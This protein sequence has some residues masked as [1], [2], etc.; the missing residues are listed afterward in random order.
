MKVILAIADTFRR[1]HLS[2]YGDAPWGKIHTPNLTRFASRAAVFDNAFIGSFPTG[3]N[4]RDTI[5]GYC[6]AGQPFNLWTD[7]TRDEATFV[8][9][10]SAKK[11]PSMLI[12]DVQNTVSKAPGLHRDFS[13]WTLVR[14]QEGD[15]MWLDENVPYETPC[16]QELMRYSPEHW[17]R[18]LVN[19]AH[20]QVETDWFAPKTY[21]TAIEWLERNYRRK[22]F[23][24]WVDT[25]DP[26]EP[27]DPPQHYI[28]LYDPGYKG[29]VIEAPPGGFRKKMGITDREQR[30]TRARYAAEVTMVDTWFGR[31]VETVERLGILDDTMIIFTSDHGTPLAGPG[32]F[33]LCRKPVVVG[34]DG[35]IASA[36][37]KAKP[38]FTYLPLSL[39]TTRIPLV[40]R[41]PRLRTG[42]RIG[43]IT[44][45]WDLAPTILDAFGMAKPERMTGGS[46][47]PL[48]AGKAKAIRNAAISGS[49]HLI[50]ATDGRWMYSVWQ[51]QRPATLYDRRSDPTCKR[52]VFRKEPAAA[53]RMHGRIAQFLRAQGL[54]E[55]AVASY[56]P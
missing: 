42:K 2:A 12:T 46:L 22:D 35:R 23:F 44:Q 50:Q 30:H 14:G 48:I 41:P 21:S 56:K 43:A 55:D 7:L 29:R 16:P 49:G 17:Q 25:F 19:R 1:D 51:G 13:A 28:D 8:Q 37:R 15:R 11:V 4:R 39:N 54:G 40:I 34:A 26:H 9:S 38:P 31:M 45:P 33:D 24:L 10:L 47:L 52:N 27:W 36:G 53:R 18:I 5:M 6:A 20:R 32:D 3:P